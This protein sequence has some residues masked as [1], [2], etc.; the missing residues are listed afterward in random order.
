MDNPPHINVA[1]C[2]AFIVAWVERHIFGYHQGEMGGCGAADRA[3]VT[4]ITWKKYVTSRVQ[5][6]T[7]EMFSTRNTKKYNSETLTNESLPS[8]RVFTLSPAIRPAHHHCVVFHSPQ[9]A[10]LDQMDDALSHLRCHHNLTE[11]FNSLNFHH[12]FNCLQYDKGAKK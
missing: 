5:Q 3:Y 7:T 2:E 4:L 9:T 12:V 8:P 1:I 6:Q 11:T 10:G